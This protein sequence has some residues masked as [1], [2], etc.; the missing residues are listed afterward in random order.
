ME[1]QTS[2]STQ[3]LRDEDVIRPSADQF[4]AMFKVSSML[5]GGAF[6]DVFKCAM[7]KDGTSRMLALKVLRPSSTPG[8]GGILP[9]VAFFKEARVLKHCKHE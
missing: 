4:Q 7:K 5:G 6:G 1:P 3:G 8:P 2:L 9:E